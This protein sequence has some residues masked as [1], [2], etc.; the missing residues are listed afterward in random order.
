MNEFPAGCGLLIIY[1]CIV[2]Y[3]ALTR[4]RKPSE[5]RATVPRKTAM[6]AALNRRS[7]G[8]FWP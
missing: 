2:L 5:P 3:R 6:F 1:A 8:A 4:P 7:H